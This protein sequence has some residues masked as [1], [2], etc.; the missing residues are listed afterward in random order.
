MQTSWVEDSTYVTLRIDFHLGHRIVILHILLAYLATIL[1]SLD[2]LLQVIGG[3]G[4]AVERG[5]RDECYR[6][7]GDG[8][9]RWDVSG[10]NYLL[11]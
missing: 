8:G 1:D 10:Q 9:L 4:A 7:S 11:G 6:G 5:L 2:A 3:D